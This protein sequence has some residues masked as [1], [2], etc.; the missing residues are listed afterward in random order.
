VESLA[1]PSFNVPL[2]GV[3]FYKLAERPRRSRDHAEYA[4]AATRF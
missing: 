4:R 2:K 3:Y 1:Y